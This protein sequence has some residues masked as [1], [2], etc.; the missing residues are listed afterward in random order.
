M[1]SLKKIAF[2]AVL[3]AVLM[4]DL[5]LAIS[6]NPKRGLAA[7]EDVKIKTTSFKKDFGG[8]N[9]QVVWQYNWDS[10]TSN[11]QPFCEY[12]PM[13]WTIP[14]NPGVWKRHATAWIDAGTQHLLAFNEP[15]NAGQSNIDPTTAVNAYRK[16]MQPFAGQVKLGAPAVSNDGYNWMS[17]FL[18]NCTGCSI[19]FVPIHWYNPSFLLDDFKAFTMKMCDLV[20]GRPIWVTEFMPTGD[21]ATAIAEFMKDAIAWLDQEDCVE[22]YAYFGTADGY[23]SLLYDNGPKL[24]ALGKAYAY[25]PYGGDA[26][27]HMNTDGHVSYIKHPRCSGPAGTCVLDE[28]AHVVWRKELLGHSSPLVA[29][30]EMVEDVGQGQNTSSCAGPCSVDDPPPYDLDD[31]AVEF[32]DTNVLCAGPCEYVDIEEPTVVE[33]PAAGA[34][35]PKD[36]PP[37]VGPCSVDLPEEPTVVKV[38]AAAA[39]DPKNG[40]PCVGPCG[41]D[42]N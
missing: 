4:A 37:C 3:M 41:V 20:G 5:L 14:E 40:P 1:A 7:N 19:D 15:E 26:R 33:V 25:T 13:L 21:N 38:P 8:N 32:N 10:N 12:V 35:D 34:T 28:D 2:F 36:G 11:K 31:K 39:T 17:Q 24:S 23:T 16:Y 29:R 30:E 18:D 27:P 22:R 42:A 6:L 9:S